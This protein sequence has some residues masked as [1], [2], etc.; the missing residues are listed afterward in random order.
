ME[1]KLL[2]TEEDKYL[3]KPYSILNRTR[4][5]FLLGFV[6]QSCWWSN[7]HWCTH[8]LSDSMESNTWPRT[9]MGIYQP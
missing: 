8:P 4:A 1:A 5:L 3:K 7:A 9:P 6:K 2:R